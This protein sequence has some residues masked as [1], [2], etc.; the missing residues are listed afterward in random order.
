MLHFAAAVRRW[1]LAGVLLAGLSAVPTTADAV[2][3]PC[4]TSYDATKS[5]CRPV[6]ETPW[7]FYIWT[8]APNWAGHFT[9]EGEAVAYP[10]SIYLPAQPNLCAYD[11]DHVAY[12]VSAPIT[13]V[14]IVI[15][16]DHTAYYDVTSGALANPP[17]QSQTTSGLALRQNREIGRAHV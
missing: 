9:S 6:I 16:R 8:A 15:R 14:G 12:D 4:S 1:L 10:P 3:P 5:K 17:C 2:V 13:Y 7:R 11:F